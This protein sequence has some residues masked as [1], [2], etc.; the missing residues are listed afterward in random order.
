MNPRCTTSV[1]SFFAGALLSAPAWAQGVDVMGPYGYTEDT[2]E[3]PQSAAV[4]IRFGPYSP[5]VDEE[6]SGSG[7]APFERF[8]GEEEGSSYMLS[9]EADWQMLR[10]P[11]FGS[12]GPGIGWGMTSFD[13][14]TFRSNGEEASQTTSLTLMPMYAVGVLR[15]DVIARETPVPLVPY[16]KFGLGYALWWTDDGIGLSRDVNG[17]TGEGASYGYQ[18]ALGL[19]LLL[20]PFDRTSARDLDSTAGVNNS[21]LFFEWYNSDLNGFDS[22]DQMQ[23]G[24]NTWMLG[25]AVEM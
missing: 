3:S 24:T 22:G 14:T 6:F 8:F 18:W 5:N 10:I 11:H 23:V 2:F 19:M 4:E 12:L 17:V 20:D 7:Q 21:Y 1:A 13:G 16:A 25:L 9:F 15:A